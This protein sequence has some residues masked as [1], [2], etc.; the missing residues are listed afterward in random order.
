MK[1][2]EKFYV[3]YQKSEDIQVEYKKGTGFIIP[4]YAPELFEKRLKKEKVKYAFK[5]LKKAFAFLLK[6]AIINLSGII[7][8]AVII[9]VAQAERGYKAIGGE[10]FLIILVMTITGYICN[11]LFKGKEEN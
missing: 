11:K 10:W 5:I 9:P 6:L 3:K 4:V 1:I 2:I 8:A 7:T